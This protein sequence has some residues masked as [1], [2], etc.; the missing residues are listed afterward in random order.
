MIE[1]IAAC[2]AQSRLFQGKLTV[3]LRFHALVPRTICSFL[4]LFNIYCMPLFLVC[5]HAK[6]DAFPPLKQLMLD[7]EKQ[8]KFADFR[9]GESAGFTSI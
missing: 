7:S 5:G 8:H 6:T 4:S 2:K 1:N 3:V 9:V